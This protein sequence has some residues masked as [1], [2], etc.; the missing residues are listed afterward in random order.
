M[1]IAFRTSAVLFAFFPSLLLAQTSGTAPA[2]K[3][4]PTTA[5]AAAGPVVADIK[6]AP[7]RAKIY[8][9]QNLGHHRFDMRDATILDL[10][11]FA[12]DRRDDTILGG[13]TWIELD[14]FDVAAKI[15]SLE[16][17]KYSAP[18]ADG[19]TTS[20]NPYKT[21]EPVIKRVLEERFQLKTHIEQRSMPGYTLT[22]AK[23]GLK[24][25]EAKDPAALPG[26]H[27]EQ[28]K[29]VPG[30]EII[31]CTSQT[32]TELVKEFGGVYPHELIDRTGLTKAYD[33]TMHMSFANLNTRDEY[34]RVYTDA[35]RQLGFIVAPGD[36]PQ[37]A[38]V[39]DS[40]QRPSPNQPD[41]AM[42]I[43]PPLDLEF[44][45]AT[46]KPAAEGEQPDRMRATAT[47][48]TFTAFTV[49]GLLT[50]AFQFPTGA[51]ISN[52]PP[53]LNV[54]RYTVLVKLPPDIDGRALY[55]S[56]DEIAIMLQKLMA[57]R[58]GL[59]YHWGEQTLDGWVLLGGT[60]KMKKA[61][62]NSRSFCK[63]G[64]PPGEKDVA[65]GPDSPYDNESHCQNVTMAQFADM[66]QA[67]TGSD[68]KYRVFDKTN[69]A[70]SWDLTLYYSSAA[71]LRAA[72]LAAD[73]KAKEA[74]ADA[75]ADPVGGLSLQDAVRKE[76]GIQLVKQPETYPALVLDHIEQTPT[77]N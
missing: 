5:A 65:S 77:E 45:V 25:T 12:Y 27:F 76:L 43:P 73:A 24:A 16:P 13:P 28:D 69:L 31:T 36:V 3:D 54:A 32:A 35:L 62:P 71:K 53:W 29:A 30:G 34:I 67:I 74:G 58:F 72:A 56:Q 63:W 75:T 33:F 51:M 46:I 40:V 22:V 26:C 1:K 41:I 55:Q 66:M 21:I 70:G 11:A 52:R 9:S 14:R 6:P 19:P 4:A 44:E 7:Y 61:D 50:R 38:L 8:Y 49:Q 57:D 42:L 60:P 64:A 47:E 15:D 20:N 2:A 37:P 39:V 68:I 17:Q 59:K 48:I 18:S 10:I 23:D